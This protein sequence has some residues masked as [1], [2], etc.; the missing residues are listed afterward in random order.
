[1]RAIFLGTPEFAVPTLAAL[2]RGEHR[3][4]AVFTQPDRPKGRGNSLAQSPVRVGA[5]EFGIPVYQPARIRRAENVE[6]LKSLEAEIFVVVGYGQI[7]PQAII[8]IPP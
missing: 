6:L 1:M 4:V 3:V 2:V 5:A 8:D 7:I